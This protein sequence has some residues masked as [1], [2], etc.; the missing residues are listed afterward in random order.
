[1][2]ILV[3]TDLSQAAANAF[4]YA[5]HLAMHLEADLLTVHV[6]P[7]LSAREAYDRH[8]EWLGRIRDKEGGR[9]LHVSHV[10]KQGDVAETVLECASETEAGIIVM[11]IG[12]GRNGKTLVSPVALQ[13]MARAGCFVIALP[14]RCSY[15]PLTKFVLLAHLDRLHLYELH[16]IERLAGLFNAHINVLQVKNTFAP[17]DQLVLDR[18]T[19]RFRGREVS[20]H[21][22]VSN[23]PGLADRIEEYAINNGA[24]VLGLHLHS[25]GQLK[26]VSQH[27]LAGK[28]L[29]RLQ[30][31]LFSLSS[32]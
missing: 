12:E 4:S 11:G 5:V 22:L 3:P 25:S 27:T 24:V 18:W 17:E 15:T 31:P 29:H 2:K 32:Q 30:L 13:V 19:E 26:E 8:L 6:Q 1:M 10:L 23:E 14:E 16:R 21:I 9:E 20:F 28:L 7:G